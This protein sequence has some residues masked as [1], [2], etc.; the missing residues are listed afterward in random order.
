MFVSVLITIAFWMPLSNSPRFAP[1]GGTITQTHFGLFRYATMHAFM[2][3]PEYRMN[4]TVDRPRLALTIGIT[5]VFWGL[6]LFLLRR[7]RVSA[8]DRADAQ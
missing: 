1:E 8:G 4:W 5:V 3:E 2:K 6:V 7:S